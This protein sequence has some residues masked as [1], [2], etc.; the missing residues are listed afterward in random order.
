MV[1]WISVISGIILAFNL[2]KKDIYPVWATLFNMFISIYLATIGTALLGKYF[3]E[4]FAGSI[5][6][7]FSFTGL[8][9]F[10]FAVA[11]FLTRSF[12]TNIYKVTLPE[13]VNLIGTLSFSFTIGMFAVGTFFFV[14]SISPLNGA[15]IMGKCLA[16]RDFKHAARKPVQIACGTIEALSFQQNS[17]SL[18]KAI[19]WMQGID[20]EQSVN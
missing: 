8:W 16:S 5:S 20:I 15:P 17:K 13:R 11:E 18:G 9:I 12:L 4:A 19:L 7:C 3:P 14:L 2:R 6:K 1:F 10:C